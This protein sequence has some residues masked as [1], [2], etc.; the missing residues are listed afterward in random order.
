MTDLPPRPLRLA[1]VL[2]VTLG[3]SSSCPAQDARTSFDA[4]ARFSQTD[5]EALYKAICQGC[6]MPDGMGA[7]GAGRYPA[8][9]GN[10]N[11]AAPGYPVYLVVYGQKGMPGFGG[12]LDDRQVAAVVNHVRSHFGNNYSDKVTARDVKAVRRPGFE[13]FSLE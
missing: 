1:W 13:Y 2:L 5:G 9:A 8:L 4:P 3:A 7:T 6:H 10:D 12:Y 11:L